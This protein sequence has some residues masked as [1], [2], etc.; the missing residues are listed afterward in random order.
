MKPELLAPAGNWEMLRT[1]IK[2][3]ADAVY[4][5]VQGI[6]MR[7][8]SRNFTTEDLKEIA[9]ECHKNDVKAYLALN[10]IVYQNEIKFVEE[11][12]KKAK[13]A[14]IDAIICWDHA[15]I[16]LVKKY[17]L[18]LHI[19]TQA[20]ISNSESARFYEEQGASLCVL[21]REVTLEDLK[22]IK[23]NTSLK[24]EV[25][26]H[27][28]MCVSVSGRCFM[29]EHLYG[30]SANRGECLQPC[31]REYKVTDKETGK[32]LELDN[33]FIMSPK[34]LCTL[35]FLELVYPY[36]DV[37]KIE[38]RGRSP[39]YVKI[40]TECYREAVDCIEKNSYTKEKKDE[41][42]EKVSQV[43]N[44]GFSEGFF[45]GRPI[46]EFTDSYGSKATKTKKYVG[47]VINYYPK[48]KAMEIKV[49]SNPIKKGD[50]ILVIGP[51]T[52]TLE[53]NVESMEVK[54]E[55]V[56][57]AEKGMSVAV[58]VSEKVRKN[59]KVFLWKDKFLKE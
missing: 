4:F 58:K 41:L 32:E 42:M 43:Y 37:L 6:N 26:V 22:E 45:M 46:S 35:P 57:T 19:S 48:V 16:K 28:A 30:K 20:S 53:E 34:D 40:V 24:I 36:A 15:V 33:N 10:V 55:T 44:R 23:K 18:N 54:K 56:S 17:G 59:D 2:A 52:G 25:F 39:E 21:A 5:G 3:G 9:E 50:D 49:E 14:G 47:Y 8:T 7:S 29:S 11:V 13:D 31:R 38:G 12:L 27:G 1:A 51:T